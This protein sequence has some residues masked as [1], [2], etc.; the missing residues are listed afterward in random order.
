MA[1][2]ARNL[3]PHRFFGPGA[4]ALDDGARA[5]L[6]GGDA[7]AVA[8][9]PAVEALASDILERVA[10]ARP[11][12]PAAESFTKVALLRLDALWAEHLLNMNYLKE[13][14]QLRTLQ[15]TD[16]FQEYQREGYD[17]FQ[18]LQTRVRADAVFSMIQM[19]RAG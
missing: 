1:R 9:A 3:I 17:L 19:A 13:N 18:A 5:A 15:Q 16:P 8:A 2:D 11:A 10:A 7:A 12:R 14:V 6:R 4:L